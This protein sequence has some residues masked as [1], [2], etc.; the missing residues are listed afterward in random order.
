M[1]W[2]RLVVVWLILGL[3][4][5]ACGRKPPVRT[6]TQA[7]SEA[8][9]TACSGRSTAHDTFNSFWAELDRHYAVFDL[10][11]PGRSWH[12]VGREACAAVSS[13]MSGTDLFELIVAMA[14][15]LDDGHIQITAPDLGL[16]E[17]GWGSGYAAADAM[18]ALE[19]N[20]EER[21]LDGEL[22]RACNDHIAWGRIGSV[23]YVDL[24]SFEE[25]SETGDEHSDTA[26]ASTAMARVVRDLDGLDGVIVDIRNNEGGWDDV[27]LEVARWF[28]GPRA[29]T[30]SKARRN[31]AA[32][33]AFGEWQDVF[34]E[35]SPED[36]FAGPVVVLTSGWTFSAA[37]TFALST[38]VRSNVILLGERTSGHFSDLEHA[39]LP[40]GWSYTYSSE[41]Y[42][43]A[44]GNIYEAQGVPVDVPIGFDAEAFDSGRDVMLET[45]LQRLTQ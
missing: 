20:I 18:R 45:A 23:A 28:E 8:P 10:R 27:G 4:I 42:R 7:V 12:D 9:F 39:A 33:D 31:G 37:E 24:Q 19:R 35:A 3:T 1:S 5:T 43:A 15:E 32:H 13:T 36:G 25:L 17:T 29:L 44:D 30:Y 14:R 38:S 16:R 21:Y 40:N 11:L 41:R 2:P 6:Q 34:V 26:C 22:V